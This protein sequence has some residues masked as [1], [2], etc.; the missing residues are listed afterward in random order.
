MKQLNRN[1]LGGPIVVTDN[2]ETARLI[3]EVAEFMP[4]VAQIIPIV[5]KIAIDSN[6]LWTMT[7]IAESVTSRDDYFRRNLLS[8]LGYHKPKKGRGRKLFKCMLTREDGD[9]EEIVAA[10]IA[11][12]RSS[13][14]KLATI[15]M[16]ESD[17]SD[18]R[19]GL[20]LAK[21]IELAFDRLQLSFVKSNPLSEN[22][23]LHIWDD[24]CRNNFIYEGS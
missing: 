10:H 17:L 23:Y 2:T 15:G 11:P 20:L 22:L 14:R 5:N 7:Q 6:N 8:H 13:I 4:K 24:S 3:K 18:V 16:T 12:A 1:F 9:S 21:G 19:N